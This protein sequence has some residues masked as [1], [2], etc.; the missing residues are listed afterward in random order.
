MHYCVNDD[1]VYQ[2][3]MA[4]IVTG[5]YVANLYGSVKLVQISS[6]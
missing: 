5:K 3:E 4:K 1:W 2:W 6:Q